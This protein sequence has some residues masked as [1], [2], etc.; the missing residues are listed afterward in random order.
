[1]QTVSE[2]IIPQV[3]LAK[4]ESDRFLNDFH[5]DGFSIMRNVFSQEE[6][7]DLRNELDI[8]FAQK[9][10][11][12]AS[13]NLYGDIVVARLF[14]ISNKFRDMLV[15]EPIISLVEELCAKN[16]HIMANNA[17]RNGPGRAIS[18]WHV[19]RDHENTVE[20]PCPPGMD[21]HDAR[22]K[23]PVLR[24][25][26]QIY[27]SD[28]LTEEDGPSQYVPGSHYSGRDPNV[29]QGQTPT[30]EGKGPVNVFGRAGDIYFH[31]GQSWHRG[32]P[33]LGTKTRYLLQMSYCQ[34]WVAQRFYPFIDYKMPEHVWEGTGE[35]LQR[36]LG[37][38]PKGPYG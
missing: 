23:L 32:A 22:Y 6:C 30:F 20:F 12:T 26:V 13:H 9:E 8:I 19:D 31:N 3:P 35:R 27:L 11:Y 2:Q 18:T 38:H 33:N 16:C 4:E 21:R 36:V 14:E 7:A 17:V 5:R 1:V 25:T 15:R 34:R 10:K 29:A 28:V 24:L 37:R